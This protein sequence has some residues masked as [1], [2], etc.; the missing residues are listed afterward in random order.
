MHSSA[1]PSAQTRYAGLNRTYYEN[2]EVDNL[3]DR[4]A[5]AL[6]ESER[7]QLEGEII[8]RVTRDAVFYPLYINAPASAVH[9]GITGLKSMAGTPRVGSFYQNTWNITEWDKVT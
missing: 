3:I 6:Q 5:T 8:E 4:F 7:D 1:I 2:P 9:K